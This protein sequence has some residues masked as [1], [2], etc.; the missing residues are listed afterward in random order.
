MIS[1]GSPGPRIP[2]AEHPTADLSAV[3]FSFKYLDLDTNAKFGMNGC[4]RGFLSEFLRE[5]HRL[6]QGTV[7]EFCEYESR[8]HSHHILFAQT[9]EPNGFV[10]LPEQVEPEEYWQFAVSEDHNWRVHG[11]FIDSVFYIVWL[12]PLHQL[13]PNVN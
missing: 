6:S 5:L 7:S 2:R 9:S 13:Y 3:T 12:D 8:R 11:F 1:G 10:H 4:D